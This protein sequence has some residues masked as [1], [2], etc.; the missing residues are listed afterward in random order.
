[1]SP[2]D[3]INPSSVVPLLIRSSFN[4]KPFF[5]HQK[6]LGEG[7]TGSLPVTEFS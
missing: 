3:R 4:P 2:G 6:H 1:M 5:C 7:V